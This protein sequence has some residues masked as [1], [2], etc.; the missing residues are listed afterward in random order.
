MFSM[1][2]ATRSIRCRVIFSPLVKNWNCIIMGGRGL[3][4]FE[5]MLLG[6]VSTYVTH[7]ANCPVLVVR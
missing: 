7:H 1:M 4:G 6:S 3:G 2:G 5:R